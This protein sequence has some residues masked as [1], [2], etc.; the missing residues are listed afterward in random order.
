MWSSIQGDLAPRYNAWVASIQ[1]NRQVPSPWLDPGSTGSKRKIEPTTSSPHPEV[2]PSDKRARSKSPKEGTLLEFDELYREPT[3]PAAHNKGIGEA[4]LSSST[5]L[6]GRHRSSPHTRSPATPAPAL[7]SMNPGRQRLSPSSAGRPSPASPKSANTPSPGSGGLHPGTPLPIRSSSQRSRSGLSDSGSL[8]QYKAS[9]TGSKPTTPGR[10]AASPAGSVRH[11]NGKER[12]SSTDSTESLTKQWSRGVEAMD[13]EPL[14]RTHFRG[15]PRY[16]DD[17]TSQGSASR[18]PSTTATAGTY[19]PRTLSAIGRAA[20][21]FRDV[22]YELD[23]MPSSSSPSSRA[24]SRGNRPTSAGP[25]SRGSQASGSRPPQPS[26]SRPMG[27]ASSS[28]S[29][30]ASSAR[31]GRR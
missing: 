30:S 1:P 27:T 22:L 8:L 5:H 16:R 4:A 25:Q 9:S 10:G 12:A 18:G 6:E 3:P 29:R 31:A 13:A 7:G 15:R 20:Q 19:S 14:Q 11:N 2:P 17:V 21:E 24:Q 28:T 23:K 26:Q